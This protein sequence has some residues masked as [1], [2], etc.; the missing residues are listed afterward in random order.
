MNQIKLFCP[1]CKAKYLMV[2]I[3]GDNILLSCE[4]ITNTTDSACAET[5]NNIMGLIEDGFTWPQALKLHEKSFAF[6][7]K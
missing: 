4:H 3:D 5:I 7:N 6:P 1:Q 2:R